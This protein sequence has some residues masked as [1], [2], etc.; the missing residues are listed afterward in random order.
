MKH[1]LRKDAS[2]IEHRLDVL[3]AELCKTFTHPTRIRILNLLRHGEQSVGEL[4]EAL[5]V[6]QPSVSQH[7]TVMRNAGVLTSRRQGTN[8]FYRLTNLKVLVAFDT[9]REALVENLGEAARLS[10]TVKR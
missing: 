2:S 3:H 5:G 7:L 4:T 1:V 9:I 10:G 8:V 6:P